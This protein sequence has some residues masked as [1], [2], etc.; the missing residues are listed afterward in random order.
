MCTEGERPVD[1]Y[2]C[3]LHIISTRARERAGA[4]RGVNSLL[5]HL[6]TN[7]EECQEDRLPLHPRFVFILGRE[8]GDAG[9]W[10]CPASSLMEQGLQM[11]LAVSSS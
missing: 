8:A 5:F 10:L 4:S 7:T 3:W 11:L 2:C 9:K 1:R 6:S